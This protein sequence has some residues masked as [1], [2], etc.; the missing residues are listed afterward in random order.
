MNSM[1]SAK[2]TINQNQAGA[3]LLESVD[4]NDFEDRIY[5]FAMELCD[6]RINTIESKYNIVGNDGSP[7]TDEENV[8][9]YDEYRDDFLKAVF[10]R[11]KEMI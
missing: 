6:D 1:T 8:C 9:W 2:Q 11:I 7:Y 10:E 4:S 5:N 3:L